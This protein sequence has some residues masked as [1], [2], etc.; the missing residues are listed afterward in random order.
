MSRIRT[1]IFACLLTSVLVS[2]SIAKWTK[3]AN[4]GTP[5][6]CCYFTDDLTGYAGSG[7][8]ASQVPI[9]I[10]YTTNG[11]SSWT[12][13]GVP[14]ASGQVTQIC[15][16]PDGTG[17]ASIYSTGSMNVN[18]WKT[19]DY[20]R[21]W[22]DVS[23]GSHLGAGVGVSSGVP[24]TTANWNPPLNAGNNQNGVFFMD[25]P[26]VLVTPGPNSKTNLAE[27]WSA[28]GDPKTRIWYTITELSRRMWISTNNGASWSSRFAFSPPL[29]TAGIMTGHIFGSAG[30]L[31]VQTEQ[32]GMIRGTLKDSGHTW[33]N[34]GGPSNIADTRTFYVGG[35]SGEMVIAFDKL[36]GVWKTNDG[37]DGTLAVKSEIGFTHPRF[38]NITA[39]LNESRKFVIT[40]YNCYDYLL[41]SISFVTNTGGAYTLATPVMP[42]TIKSGATDTFQLAFDPAKKPGNYTC[43]VKVNGSFITGLPS[44]AFDSLLDVAVFVTGEQPRMQVIPS[45]LELDTASI[46]GGQSDTVFT[47]TNTSCDTLTITSGP[48]ALPPEFTIDPL[49]LP[50]KL[51]K[52][53]TVSLRCHFKPTTAGAKTAN[54]IYAATMQ[55]N[56]TS[57]QMTLNGF[58]EDGIA[59]LAASPASIDLDTL[60]LCGS[61]DSAEVSITNTGCVP[62]FL[63]NISIGGDPD[64]SLASAPAPWRSVAPGDV[65]R[66][67]V[68]FVPS[69]KGKRTATVSIVSHSRSVDSTVMRFSIPVT[70]QVV[71]GFAKPQASVSALDFGALS[72]CDTRDTSFVIRNIGCD[73]LRVDSLTLA[74]AGFSVVGLSLPTYLAPNERIVVKV[75]ASPVGTATTFSGIIRVFTTPDSNL[76]PVTLTFSLKGTSPNVALWLTIDS[77][78]ATSGSPTAVHLKA[79]P[80]TIGQYRSLDVTL[81]WNN[82]LLSHRGSHG[83]NTVAPSGPVTGIAGPWTF[84]ITGNPFL[85]TDAADSSVA[86]LDYD[87][88]LTKDTAT[89]V[90]LSVLKVNDTIPGSG[91]CTMQASASGTS[92]LYRIEGC[93]QPTLHDYL[94]TGTLRVSAIR[95]NPVT[96]TELTIVVESRV[97]QTATISVHDELGKQ[98]LV[99]TL[100]LAAGTNEIPIGTTLLARGRY[101]VRIVTTTSEVTSGF[102]RK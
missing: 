99:R 36:G 88:F 79:D 56:N 87:V 18:L 86:V 63:D 47:I 6:G 68:H 43:R 33:I 1:I 57:V 102:V 74:G 51:P 98:V 91:P 14:T 77:A 8:S 73:S 61:G 5:V 32:D 96:G 38:P 70:A 54:P 39:C 78:S 17:Y 41:N 13:A 2:A 27:A 29:V 22:T 62:L 12:N 92:F 97:K 81:N 7:N 94:S 50:Y 69:L 85:A 100:E 83:V 60:S 23:T 53:S 55:G 21:S 49:A 58:G 11:G 84:R 71:S 59:K 19:V 80:A 9:Q 20:G 45:T 24:L 31:Y 75:H 40:N 28:W 4:L 37:G 35:C 15:I 67:W 72:F 16:L 10:W 42:D 44:V 101:S 93:S 34:V 82:D 25:S 30:Y 90:D 65:V 52:D 26:T 48:G 76:A 89:S 95:P 66:M 64:Y 46:C 3:I